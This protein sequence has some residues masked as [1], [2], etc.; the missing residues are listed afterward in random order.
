[1]GPEPS[2]RNITGTRPDNP[3]VFEPASEFNMPGRSLQIESLRSQLTEALRT[4]FKDTSWDHGG[5]I[6]RALSLTIGSFNRDMLEDAGAALRQAFDRELRRVYNVRDRDGSTIPVY[7]YYAAR[8]EQSEESWHYRPARAA[9]RILLTTLFQSVIGDRLAISG[10]EHLPPKD[11]PLRLLF[12][13]NHRAYFDV[14]LLP[15]GLLSCRRT[16]ISQRLIFLIGPKAFNLPV[17]N[18]FICQGVNSIKVP[19]S[20][21]IASHEALLSK[22]ETLRRGRQAFEIAATR[23]TRG[24]HLAVFPEGLRS[25]SGLCLLSGTYLNNILPKKVSGTGLK[26]S[27][28][29]VIPCGFQGVDAAFPD[30]DAPAS[31]L[32][33]EISLR[34]GKGIPGELLVELSKKHPPRVAEHV[35]G[36]RLAELLPEA[37]RGVYGDHASSYIDHPCWRLRIT[38]EQARQI[39]AARAI[40]L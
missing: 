24:D 25:H 1:M 18:F 28:I 30:Q 33:G 19:Q 4:V 8:Q 35:I 12:V 26:S 16:D 23:M 32:S 38:A 7:D 9:C 5:A 37:M 31:P 21:R 14:G 20:T 39:E 27:D 34:F 3:S 11:S 17:D 2:Y 6:M 36:H 15:F 29:M 22:Q 10:E 13:I 40:V